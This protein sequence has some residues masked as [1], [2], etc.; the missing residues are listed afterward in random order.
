MNVQ[1]N[2]P[3]RPIHFFQV[4]LD[5]HVSYNVDLIM[6]IVDP[7]SNF[8]FQPVLYNRYNKGCDKCYPVN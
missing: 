3:I 8:I 6:V 2:I 4:L 1:V 7:I 5:Q